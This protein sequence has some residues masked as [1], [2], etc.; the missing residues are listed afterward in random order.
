MPS[1][2]QVKPGL[3]ATYISFSNSIFK[4]GIIMAIEKVEKITDNKLDKA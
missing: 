4:K 1:L 3:V 2:L